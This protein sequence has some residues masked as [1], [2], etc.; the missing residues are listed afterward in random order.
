MFRSVDD[1]YRILKLHQEEAFKKH[2]EALRGWDVE[3]VHYWLGYSDAL[4]MAKE[5]L[6]PFVS[7][8]VLK[9]ERSTPAP[10]I[11]LP[12]E[13]PLAETENMES[14]SSEHHDHQDGHSVTVLTADLTAALRRMTR[15]RK[16][17]GRREMAVI[18]FRDGMLTISMLNASEGIPAEGVW[19]D[20][21]IITSHILYNCAKVPPME[22]NVVI[23][24]M[25]DQ[26]YIGSAATPVHL[27]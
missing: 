22:K 24:V 17:S 2:K 7:Q 14:S 11:V 5:A 19:A 15:F 13:V 21:I 9:F 12:S 6:R 27:G 26:F 10:P 20:D 1:T 18:S 8:E 25:N 4:Q 16:K 3:K 23:K